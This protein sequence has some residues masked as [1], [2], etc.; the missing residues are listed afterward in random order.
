MGDLELDFLTEN[1]KLSL[2]GNSKECHHNAKVI[3]EVLKNKGYPVKLIRGVYF[4]ESKKISHSW[5]ETDDL[6]L[7]T[8]CKQLRV[9]CDSM[10]NIPFGVLKKSDFKYRYLGV[11]ND[12]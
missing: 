11:S 10:P 9:E 2:H 5:I 1:L 12:N 8:D 6:I 3:F 7:E 4:N